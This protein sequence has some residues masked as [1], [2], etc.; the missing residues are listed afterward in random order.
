[1]DTTQRDGAD[2][3]GTWTLLHQ[4]YLLTYKYLDQIVSR[5]GVSQAQASVLLVLKGADEPLPLSRLARYLVQ[6]AQ[7][8]TSLVDRLELRGFVKRVPDQRDRRVIHVE[9]TP[10]GH[11]MF[12]EIF[13]R[14]LNGC[15][16]VFTGLSARELK[17]FGQLCGKVRSRSADLMGMDRAPFEK[18][19]E[20]L[21][22]AAKT[23]EEHAPVSS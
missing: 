9:L 19:T 2:L 20:T 14:A 4:A 17:E 13:P 18:A 23:Y 8:V 7:S 11:K 1:M 12:D 5:L 10:E 21:R 3:F 22:C 6:E 16:E 15:G